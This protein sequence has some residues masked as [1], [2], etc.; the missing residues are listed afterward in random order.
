MKDRNA[1]FAVFVDI[2]VPNFGQEAEG[3]CWKGVVP[4]KSDV[5]FEVAARVASPR[6]PEDGNLPVENVR[7]IHVQN[8]K[9]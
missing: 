1:H 6:R 5:C 9:T 2:G 4:G 7:V 3:R 8:T